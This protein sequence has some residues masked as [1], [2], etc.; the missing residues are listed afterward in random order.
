MPSP[1]SMDTGRY[2]FVERKQ[3][4]LVRTIFI[5]FIFIVGDQFPQR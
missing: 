1:F 3:Y 2:E 5:K 4:V